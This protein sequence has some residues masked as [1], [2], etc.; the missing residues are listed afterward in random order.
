M[1]L[2]DLNTVFSKHR[3]ELI[4]VESTRAIVVK[5]VEDILNIVL[6]LQLF[7]GFQVEHFGL[8]RESLG[9]P[10]ASIVILH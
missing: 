1:L 5:V 10:L 6:S 4:Y 9:K 3:V 8:L 2:L 7:L